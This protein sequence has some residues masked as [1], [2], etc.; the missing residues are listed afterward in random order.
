MECE[1]RTGRR[2]PLPR[3]VHPGRHRRRR[4]NPTASS[5]SR[6]FEEVRSG[7][8]RLPDAVTR[9]GSK[10]LCGQEPFGVIRSD[11]GRSPR[12]CPVRFEALKW[13]RAFRVNTKRRGIDPPPTSKGGSMGL[14]PRATYVE[15]RERMRILPL[16]S[17]VQTGSDVSLDGLVS[18]G[19]SHYRTGHTIPHTLWCDHP[20]TRWPS[21]QR[22][23]G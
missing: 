7:S 16:R 9:F 18:S 22:H 13:E 21:G 20:P 10:P 14:Y 23:S 4:A 3:P 6:G 5:R 19:R 15:V 2:G 1:G 8:G 17:A 12:R 11:G